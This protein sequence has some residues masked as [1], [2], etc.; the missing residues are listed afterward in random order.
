MRI[1]G[2]GQPVLNLYP[3]SETEFFVRVI[4]VRVVFNQGSD[5]TVESLTLVQ[6]GQEIV[7][8]RVN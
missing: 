6:N 2:T 7:A 4:D 8:P 1:Q 5:G 3:T